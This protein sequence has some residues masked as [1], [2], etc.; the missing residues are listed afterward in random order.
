MSSA[1]LRW[2]TYIHNH[3]LKLPIF[4]ISGH[5]QASQDLALWIGA[6]FRLHNETVWEEK[7]L[8][9]KVDSSPSANILQ[10]RDG[11][12]KHQKKFQLCPWHVKALKLFDDFIRLFSNAIWEICHSCDVSSTIYCFIYMLIFLR[13]V[14]VIRE[15]D[16]AELCLNWDL[17][18]GGQDLVVGALWA[19][20]P[21]NK[22]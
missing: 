1:S 17:G 2:H 13:K 12:Q 18:E 9:F 4:E 15:M 3:W 5:K 16:L 11:I 10:R 22:A 19:S 8:E 6:Y 14:L 21:A 20:H 7:H